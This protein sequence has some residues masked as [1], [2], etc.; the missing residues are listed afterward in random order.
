MAEPIRAGTTTPPTNFRQQEVR[1]RQRAVTREAQQQAPANPNRAAQDRAAG[2][3][4]AADNRT[5][6]NRA[7]ESAVTRRADAQRANDRPRQ[8][9]QTPPGQTLDTFA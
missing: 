2:D 5:A 9:P 1:A 8:T 7:A 6:D 3:A 4:R